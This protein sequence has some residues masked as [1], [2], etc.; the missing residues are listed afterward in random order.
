MYMMYVGTDDVFHDDDDNED[1][2]VH[3][4]DEMMIK[5]MKV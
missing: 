2:V 4:D 5:V 3:D 1:D